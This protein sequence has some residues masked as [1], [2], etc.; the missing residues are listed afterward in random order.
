MTLLLGACMSAS[1]WL[2]GAHEVAFVGFV[3]AA[4]ARK[5]QRACRGRLA[6]R[7]VA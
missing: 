6:R 1:I 7:V 4:L 5:P 2:A 3:L